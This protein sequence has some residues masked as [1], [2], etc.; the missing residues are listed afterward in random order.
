MHMIVFPGFLT[1]VLT[2][3]FFPKPQT[4]LLICFCRGER[5]ECAR[6]KVRFNWVSNSQPPGHDSDKLTTEL[7]WQ[8][9][10]SDRKSYFMSYVTNFKQ[11]SANTFSLVT[12][13]LTLYRTIQ[14]FNDP[15]KEAFENIVGKGENAVN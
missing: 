2:Q 10:L 14:T 11:L 9:Y 13:E 6:K 3:L 8:A 15:E 1:S 4:T 12:I 7:P 5:R